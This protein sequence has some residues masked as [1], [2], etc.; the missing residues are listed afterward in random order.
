MTDQLYARVQL[1]TKGRPNYWLHALPGRTER[2]E[3]CTDYQEATVFTLEK[4]QQLAKLFGGTVN[5]K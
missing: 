1:S 4:A 3:A 5:R 2:Y